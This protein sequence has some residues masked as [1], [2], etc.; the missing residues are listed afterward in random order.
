[1]KEIVRVWVNTEFSH[2][3]RHQRRIDKVMAL[4]K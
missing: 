3:E 2:D 4:E 1:M